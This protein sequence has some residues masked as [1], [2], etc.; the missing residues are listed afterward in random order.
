MLSM[1]LNGSA[2]ETQMHAATFTA[3]LAPSFESQPEDERLYEVV[4]PEGERIA[5]ATT[6]LA[7]QDLA[8]RLNSSCDLWAATFGP[9]AMVEVAA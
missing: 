3:R 2:P 4:T 7:V 9:D 5:S 6:R 8:D 1:A